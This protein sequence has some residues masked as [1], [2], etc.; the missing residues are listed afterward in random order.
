MFRP[1]YRP[2]GKALEYADL[3]LNL[4]DTCD[5]GCTYCW[6]KM[7]YE[8]FHGLGSFS[9]T[10]RVREGVLEALEKQCKAGELDGKKVLL[11]FTCDPYSPAAVKTG[12]TR[13]AMLI[14][15]LYGI[16]FTVLTKGGTV[17]CEDFDLYQPGCSFG[18]TLTFFDANESWKWE[19]HAADPFNRCTAI[20]VAHNYGIKTWVSLEPVIVPQDALMFVRGLHGDVD[21]WKVGKWNYDPRAKNIDWNRFGHEIEKLFQKYGC[22]YY[23]KE[24]LRKVM[25][26]GEV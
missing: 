13:K 17:A 20:K 22:E 11:C 10:P 6:S 8:R 24:D 5:H 21:L 2:K 16:Q 3:A 1:V 25:T 9:K 12:A 4:Y 15:N 18:T 23:I 14:L 7:M 19:P 26:K